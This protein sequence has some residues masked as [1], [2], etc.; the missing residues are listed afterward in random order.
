MRLKITTEY[1]TAEWVEQT[2]KKLARE[3]EVAAY[4]FPDLDANEEGL[5]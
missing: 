3:Y 5:R 1:G 2:G 4:D